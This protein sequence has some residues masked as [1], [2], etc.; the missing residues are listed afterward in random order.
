MVRYVAAVAATIGL[1][2]FP[3]VLLLTS[4]SSAIL[5][6][7]LAQKWQLWENECIDIP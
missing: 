4:N 2:I 1:L 5:S 6:E 3:S 7:A